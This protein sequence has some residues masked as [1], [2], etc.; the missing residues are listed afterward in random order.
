MTFKEF[1]WKAKYGDSPEADFVSDSLRTMLPEVT[2]WRELK[3]FLLD[4]LACDEAVEAGKKVFA[5][6]KARIDARKV[7]L[8][9]RFLIMQRDNFRCQLCG[10]TVQDGARMEI[11]HKHPV[12]LGGTDTESNLWTLCFECNRGK[13]DLSLLNSPDPT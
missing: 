8:K 6:Y 13:S 10:I 7:S 9:I 4:S 1:L 2:E 5:D 3:K 11:D 12:A